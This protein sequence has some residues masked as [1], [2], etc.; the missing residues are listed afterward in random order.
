MS[1]ENQNQDFDGEHYVPPAWLTE[2]LQIYRK[3]SSATFRN[4]CREAA[5]NV[6][7]VEGKIRVGQEFMSAT[8][9]SPPAAGAEEIFQE[10]REDSQQSK[11]AREQKGVGREPSRRGFRRLAWAGGLIALC[12]IALSCLV[13]LILW[14]RVEALT[15]ELQV[16]RQDVALFRAEKQLKE[17]REKQ[18]EEQKAIAALHFRMGQLMDRFDQVYSPRTAFLPMEG[19]DPSPLFEERSPL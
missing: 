15:G 4:R 14:K 18:E 5:E 7:A 11:A 10:K 1:K 9:P 12:L 6:V 2:A 19:A 3:Q 13:S 17:M 16:A 8:V